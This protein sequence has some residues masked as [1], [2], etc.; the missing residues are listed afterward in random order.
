MP[1]L[2]LQ[3]EPGVDRNRRAPQHCLLH[4]T[5]VNIY[6]FA[7]VIHVGWTANINNQKIYH[8]N[9]PGQLFVNSFTVRIGTGAAPLKRLRLHNIE[10]EKKYCWTINLLIQEAEHCPH[11]AVIVNYFFLSFSVT[12]S[13]NWPRILFSLFTRSSLL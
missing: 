12:I 8:R 5:K 7:S 1:I 9:S 4:T 11:D 2:H 3:L 13:R 10:N 6:N